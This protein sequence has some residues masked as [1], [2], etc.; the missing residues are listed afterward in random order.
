MSRPVVL[1]GKATVTSHVIWSYKHFVVG[2]TYNILLWPDLASSS[3][4]IRAATRQTIWA[5]RGSSRVVAIQSYEI[6]SI[7]AST[8]RHE[9]KLDMHIYC[10]T[11]FCSMMSSI[12]VLWLSWVCPTTV[13]QSCDSRAINILWGDGCVSVDGRV[14]VPRMMHVVIT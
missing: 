9:A 11:I 14:S 13:L 6:V 4:R 1:D 8:Y 10:C 2:D 12:I 5:N 7:V 3:R